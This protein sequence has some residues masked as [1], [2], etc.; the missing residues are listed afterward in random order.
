VTSVSAMPAASS[1]CPETKRTANTTPPTASLVLP[2]EAVAVLV[3]EEDAVAA[4]VV[5]VATKRQPRLQRSLPAEAV[6]AVAKA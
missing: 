1:G 3:A 6:D 4:D 5:V 2:R